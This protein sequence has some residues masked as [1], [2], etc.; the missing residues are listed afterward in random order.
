MGDGLQRRRFR[1][2]DVRLRL[3]ISVG[4]ARVDAQC[5]DIESL[6]QRADAACYRA[7]QQR[8]AARS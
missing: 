5:S 4:L 8:L 3:G 2:R 6:L 7:K 1:W